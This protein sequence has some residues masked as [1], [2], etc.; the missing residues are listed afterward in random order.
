MA[1]YFRTGLFSTKNNMLGAVRH[2]WK[3]VVGKSINGD[4]HEF[5]GKSLDQLLPGTLWAD[6]CR[7]LKSSL[8]TGYEHLGYQGEDIVNL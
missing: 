8:R 2:Q 6:L 3:V 7:R 1:G 4:S 5:L